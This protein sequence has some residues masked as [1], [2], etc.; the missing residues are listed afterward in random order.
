MD[1]P[2][3]LD[4]AELVEP[5]RRGLVLSQGGATLPLSLVTS[6]QRPLNA[7]TRVT[8]RA[9]APHSPGALQLSNGNLLDATSRTTLRLDVHRDLDLLVAPASVQATSPLAR[10]VRIDVAPAPWWARLHRWATLPGSYRRHPIQPPDLSRNESTPLS[11]GLT[12]LL[13]GAVA[14][15]GGTNRSSAMRVGPLLAA[16]VLPWT[17]G[18]IVWSSLGLLM[19]L[20]GV[21]DRRGIPWAAVAVAASLQITG[22]PVLVGAASLIG[23]RSRSGRAAGAVLAALAAVQLARVLGS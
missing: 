7:A 20:A 6:R 10:T 18:P 19:A 2:H 13:L 5:L 17:G 21:V 23:S 15:E 8:L 4:E 12:L 16:I 14:R 9:T 3:A 11:A 22:L 1:V